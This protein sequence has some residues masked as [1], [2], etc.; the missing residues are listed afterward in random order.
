MNIGLF[1]PTLNRV[2]GGELITLNMI[3]ALEV[4]NH[5]IIVY[6]AEK[7]DH[8]RIENFIGSSIHFDSVTIGPKLFDPYSLQCLY[9]NLLRSY[10]FSL[11]CDILIDTFSDALLPWT[12]AVY[13]NKDPRISKLPKSGAKSQFFAPYK[14]LLRHS[15]N[16]GKA[17][18]KKLMTCSKFA[19]DR[20][21]KSLGLPVNVLYPPIS[22]FF[23]I[24]SAV[25]SKENI[26][27]T[28][29]RISPDKHPETIPKIASLLS[30]EFSFII[31]GSCRTPI[32]MQTLKSLQ[33][34]IQKLG[35]GKR[36]KLL[37]NISREKQREILQK[38]KVYL[39]PFVSYEAFG[40]SVA[41]AMS[42][43]C[44]PVAPDI[45]GLKEIVPNQLLY[46]SLEE[47]S[48]LTKDA[49]HNWSPY[50][51]H[52]SVKSVDNFSQSKF[53]ERF[54]DFMQL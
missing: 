44:V 14:T 22:D 54:V 11:K 16:E 49:V 25:S 13:F 10:L 19:A 31:V 26:V 8:S 2:G 15:S 45:G 4:K 20:I 37:L 1:S 9:P 32:E 27:A 39:H 34:S 18:Q 52:Q 24:K 46:N 35:V 23:K 38:A 12:D 7:I 33:S 47:A 51:T 36:V 6:T 53:C 48:E 43:G 29:I 40:I 41:E 21:K 50:Q 30:D 42:A 28:V 17:K 3:R 5:R